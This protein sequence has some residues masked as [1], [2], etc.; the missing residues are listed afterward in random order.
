VFRERGQKDKESV[1]SAIVFAKK[2][3]GCQ[4]P[5]QKV[6]SKELQQLWARSGEPF[7]PVDIRQL[8][9]SSIRGK[10]DER[11]DDSCF[12]LSS[13]LSVFFMLPPIS[14]LWSNVNTVGP[15]I[16][17]ELECKKH[18]E[19]NEKQKLAYKSIWLWM[20]E[21]LSKIPPTHNVVTSSQVQRPSLMALFHKPLIIPH[22]NLLHSK[23]RKKSKIKWCASTPFHSA[24]VYHHTTDQIEEMWL[25]SWTKNSK[26]LKGYK[27]KC[28]KDIRT[29]SS[30]KKEGQWTRV[31]LWE[32]S[33]S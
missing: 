24:P 6:E 10:I 1:L 26:G 27:G 17:K 14:S 23:I 30:W 15:F 11:T 18:H 22:E 3:K 7:C 8:W 25:E 33:I 20:K 9:S 29:W 28:Q 5:S 32:I 21:L 31:R 16:V 19:Q 13:K 12:V 2:W 4:L